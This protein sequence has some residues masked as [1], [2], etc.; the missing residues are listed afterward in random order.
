VSG[1]PATVPTS[2]FARFNT[3]FEAAAGRRGVEAHTLDVA[4]ATVRLRFAGSSLVPAI[5]PALAHLRRA[6][7]VPDFTVSLWD[8]ESTGVPLPASDLLPR[9][10]GLLRPVQDDGRVSFHLQVRESILT[11]F[12]CGQQRA[13]VA[14]RNG[15]LPLWERAAPLRV[16][17]QRWL[18]DRGMA[19][20]HAAGV[21]LRDGPG[22]LLTG[23]GGSGK[24][25]TAVL[26]DQAGMA[27][28]GDDYVIFDPRTD[29]AW[30]LYR[31]V[32]LDWGRRQLLSTVANS[33]AEEKALGFLADPAPK[34]P[35]VAV[36][37]PR[38]V[39]IAATTFGAAGPAEALRDLAPR[40]VLQVS[41]GAALYSGLGS[42]VRRLPI[43]RL[44]L[45]SDTDTVASAVA[46]YLTGTGVP[47]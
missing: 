30:S 20:V 27:C 9:P 6:A 15:A 14:V 40:A 12:D 7:A 23:P 4:G 5:L 35:V 41:G 31:S 32:K 19:L 21:G 33:E 17:W 10:G 47:S 38:V 36:L 22:V 42:A 29:D 13:V 25:T 43:R 28:A 34:V 1:P 24:S 2:D 8:T 44:L 46:G 45:G 26:C 11:V 37:L 16:L 39:G 18:A 3:A